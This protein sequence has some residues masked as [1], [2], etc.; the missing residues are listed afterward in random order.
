M[1][2]IRNKFAAA[3]GLLFGMTALIDTVIGVFL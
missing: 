1:F 3:L 2:D